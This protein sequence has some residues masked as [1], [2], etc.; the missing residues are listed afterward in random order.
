MNVTARGKTDFMAKEVYGPTP[1]IQ[2]KEKIIR[3]FPTG[4]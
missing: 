4:T 1:T 3:T 2:A